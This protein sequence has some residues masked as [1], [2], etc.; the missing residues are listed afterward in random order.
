MNKPKNGIL[1]KTMVLALLP[2]VILLWVVGW[3]LYYKGS[4]TYSTEAIQND[5]F[6]GTDFDSE[7]VQEKRESHVLV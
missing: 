5:I 1:R 3:V 6:S 2:V 7:E 4:E